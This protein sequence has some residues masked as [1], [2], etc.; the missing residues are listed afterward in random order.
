MPKT[1]IEALRLIQ[2]AEEGQADF[3]E[4]RLDSLMNLKGLADLAACGS[5]PKIATNK[6]PSITEKEIQLT[7]LSAAKNG[8]TYVDV[9]LSHSSPADLVKEVKNLGAQSIVSFHHHSSS[10][11]IPYLNMVLDKQISVGADICKI[12][13]TPTRLQDNL[14]L[15]QFTQIACSKIKVVCFGMGEFGKMSRLLSP[16]FGGFFTFASLKRGSETA[17]GQMTIEEMKAAYQMLGL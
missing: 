12:V 11:N 17:P 4:V 15:L 5:L 14:T 9:D 1:E 16:A 3:I 10:A 6:N 8:F 2:Q 13:T 7:L